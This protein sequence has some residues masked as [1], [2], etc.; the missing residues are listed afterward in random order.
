MMKTISAERSHKLAPEQQSFYSENGYS[1]PQRV[2]GTEEAA[3]F[4]T[5][6]QEYMDQNAHRLSGLLQRDRRIYF[7]DAHLFL[8]W[9][10]RIVSHP[11]I[12]DAVESVLG[13]NILVWGS[14]WFPK[15][16]GDHAYVSWHQDGTYWGLHPP[17]VTTA[18]IAVSES[19]PENGCM[20][21]VPGTHKTPKLP[22]RETFAPDNM[23][24]RGQEIAVEVDEAQAV[25]LILQPGEMSLHHIGII[26][27]SGPN[28][29]SRARIGLAVRY[30]GPEVMQDGPA[31][32]IALLVRGKDEYGHFDLAEPPARDTS[33][34]ESSIHAE[35]LRRK[36]ANILPKDAPG[37]K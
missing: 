30:I 13:R 22:Q 29:S 4:L 28:N 6:F 7:S 3:R 36:A 19:T 25:D 18:W 21:V 17:N 32:D 15:M 10:Y 5:R 35:A 2:L 9:V 24:S 27:G 1:F 14:Q 31:R 12:L 20:R 33:P 8:A 23:L 37:P 34:E 26:H 16:P 11:S